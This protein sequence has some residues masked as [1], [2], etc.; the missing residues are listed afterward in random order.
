MA[1]RAEAEPEIDG[2]HITGND[3]DNDDVN[4]NVNVA[5]SGD[6]DGSEDHDLPLVRATPVVRT[7]QGYSNI[8]TPQHDP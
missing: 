6:G 8:S 1:Q 5:V 7:E 4:V 3:G 2:K